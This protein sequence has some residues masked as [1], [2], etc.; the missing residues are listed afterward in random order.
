MARAKSHEQ[1]EMLGN[2]QQ[3]KTSSYVYQVANLVRNNG[4]WYLTI[5]YCN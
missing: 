3:R 5:S 4:Q 1:I 2:Q